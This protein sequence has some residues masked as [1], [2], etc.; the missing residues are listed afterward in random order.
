MR[1]ELLDRAQL[2][3]GISGNIFKQKLTIAPPSSPSPSQLE[4]IPP[5]MTFRETEALA[6]AISGSLDN[7]QRGWRSCLMGF[8]MGN[9][10]FI[11]IAISLDLVFAESRGVSTRGLSSLTPRECSFSILGVAGVCSESNSA[12]TWRGALRA[13][14]RVSDTSSEWGSSSSGRGVLSA[15]DRE[16]S[17]HPEETPW[18]QKDLLVF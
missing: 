15:R 13:S 2:V 8:L 17:R 5:N 11:G 6:N 12:R 10:A 3:S 18:T 14:E 4:P 1:F 9:I 7:R 16:L